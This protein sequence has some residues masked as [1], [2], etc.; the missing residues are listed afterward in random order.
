MIAFVK[1]RLDDAPPTLPAL[2][3]PLIKERL[4]QYCFV[5]EMNANTHEGIRMAARYGIEVFPTVV[6]VDPRNLLEMRR[7]TGEQL[8]IAHDFLAEYG[9]EI[10]LSNEAGALS[11]ADKG[12][13]KDM[14]A[15]G[16]PPCV[17]RFHFPCDDGS[18]TETVHF[19]MNTK[20][21]A[22]FS[23]IR[24]QGF[25]PSRHVLVLSFP[26]R[27]FSTQ[28]G[29]KTLGEL[30]FSKS[31]VVHVDSIGSDGPATAG[32]SSGVLKK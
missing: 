6:V 23:F 28:H 27:E 3:C 15:S 7:I 1:R 31:E 4:S 20:L 16:G 17:V 18:R 25:V 11:V 26:R 32:P 21:A 5:T 10:R 22:L 12:E 19:T 24:D 14:V 13:W 9:D 30:G 8:G 29:N 2:R